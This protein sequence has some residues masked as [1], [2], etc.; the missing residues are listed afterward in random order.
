MPNTIRQFDFEATVMAKSSELPFNPF[1][2][3]CLR[4]YGATTRDGAPL[5]SADLMSEQEI[6]QHIALLKADLDAV[7]RLA[8]SG[9]K[10][11]RERTM[12]LVAQRATE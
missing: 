7:A 5:I 8:K 1:V 12:R 6:D 9:L 2:C 3:L 11:A 10:R 4:Q